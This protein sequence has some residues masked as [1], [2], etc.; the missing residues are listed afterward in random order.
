MPHATLPGQTIIH[1]STTELTVIFE[2]EHNVFLYTLIEDNKN[3]LGFLFKI[4]LCMFFIEQIMLESIKSIGCVPIF[5]ISSYKT[6]IKKPGLDPSQL[7]NYRSILEKLYHSNYTQIYILIIL[8]KWIS[9]DFDLT[10]AQSTVKV[11]NDLLFV[12]NQGCV[13]LLVLLDLGV[14]F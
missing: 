4:I 12:S 8:M 14:A 7:S 11:V 6:L 10:I 3:N 9:K 5:F 1:T 2:L 13:S